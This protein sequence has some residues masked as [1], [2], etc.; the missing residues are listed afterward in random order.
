M[1]NRSLSS[2]FHKIETTIQDLRLHKLWIIYP[3][4]KQYVLSDKVE[5]LP[6][7]SCAEAL[8]YLR[9]SSVYR[10]SATMRSSPRGTLER[11][12]EG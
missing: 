6:L 12:Q 9:C 8:R 5:A 2:T 4:D 10:E 7:V 11:V 1:K 3:G